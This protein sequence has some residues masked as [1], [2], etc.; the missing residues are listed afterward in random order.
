MLVTISFKFGCCLIFRNFR[1]P[2]K[3]LPLV[4]GLSLA[5]SSEVA[6]LLDPPPPSYNKQP[7]HILMDFHCWGKC[8]SFQ[9]CEFFRNFLAPF[10][11][12][13]L[14]APRQRI[15]LHFLLKTHHVA[16]ILPLCYINTINT[17]GTK[18]QNYWDK[19]RNCW[20]ICPNSYTVNICKLFWLQAKGRTVEGKHFVGRKF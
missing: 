16:E 3:P 8:H 19:S 20:D 2:N 1:I 6:K 12:S 13:L 15:F 9:G 7:Q 5:P 4:A 11:Q 10:F 14:S 17:V 18:R